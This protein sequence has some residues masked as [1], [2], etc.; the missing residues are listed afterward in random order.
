MHLSWSLYSFKCY[1]SYVL[2][3]HST[4]HAQESVVHFTEANPPPPK[5]FSLARSILRARRQPCLWRGHLAA[6]SP[7]GFACGALRSHL[8]QHNCYH[9]SWT[10]ILTLL[11]H[12]Y[13]PL[14]RISPKPKA[15][16]YYIKPICLFYKQVI[17]SN[18]NHRQ[19]KSHWN[20]SK[21]VHYICI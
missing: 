17:G 15:W 8:V 7:A 12:V 2:L 9:N 4:I 11:C 1:I 13:H 16:Q 3:M 5:K 6:A 10:T 14:P 20:S 21:N 18:K 19:F